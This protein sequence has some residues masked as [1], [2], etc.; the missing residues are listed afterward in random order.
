MQEVERR[1]EESR[2]GRMQF[3][4]RSIASGA[5]GGRRPTAGG[6]AV[7]ETAPSALGPW[8]LATPQPKAEASNLGRSPSSRFQ[9]FSSHSRPI[10]THF[11]NLILISA[12][13]IPST[14]KK[15]CILYIMYYQV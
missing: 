8:H 3:R 7:S 6:I 11:S 4:R 5:A 13:Y 12:S 14:Q 10:H 15:S 9:H 1:D 2:C